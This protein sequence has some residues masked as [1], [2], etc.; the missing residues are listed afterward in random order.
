MQ[1]QEPPPVRADLQMGSRGEEI[2][3]LGRRHNEEWR[4]ANTAATEDSAAWGQLSTTWTYTLNKAELC[5]GNFLNLKKEYAWNN[6]L[7]KILYCFI[8]L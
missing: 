3:I 1:V 6:S 8:H 5:L 7:C 2:L 4:V